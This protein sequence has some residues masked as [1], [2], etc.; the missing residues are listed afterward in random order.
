[1]LFWNVLQGVLVKDLGSIIFT[2]P[3]FKLGELD[4][5]LFIKSSFPE[6]SERPLEVKTSIS[7]VSLMLFKVCCFN[8]AGCNRVH[9]DEPF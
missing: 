6:L 8:I 3:N 2:L 5:E 7:M 9:V 1:M 4:E